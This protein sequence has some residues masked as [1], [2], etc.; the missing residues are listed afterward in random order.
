MA[1]RATSL[2][3]A[4]QNQFFR[5][6][7]NLPTNAWTDIYA[8]EHDYA[9]V[10]AG[11]NRD[12]LV[13]DFRQAVEKAIADGTTLEEFRRDFDRIVA[14][15]GWSYRGG[16]NW[17]SRVIYETNMRSSY[18]AGRLEQLMAVREE[19]P[20]W[21]YLHSDAVEHPRPKHESWN[22][23]V[24]RWDDPWWQYH[25]PINAWGCQCSVR[26]LSEDDLRRMGKD[27]PDEAPPIVWQA[28][29]IGQNSPDG[30]R[31]V[32]VPEGIDPGFEYMP[33]QARLDTAVPQPRNGGP[34]PPAGLPSTPASDPLPAPRPVPTN[35]L[36]DQDML[37]ADAI[38][39]FL[40][41]FGATLDKPAVFQ[42]VVGQRV[43]VGREMFAS[44]AGGDL[45]V[46]ES[47]M[48]KKWLM[49]AAEALRRP[50]EIWVRLDWV[51]SLKKAVV[52]R[53]YLA[54][55][56]VSGEAA[57]VQVVVE[58]DANGW[59]ASAA[60]VQPGQQPLAPYRQGVRLYQET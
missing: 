60:V 1:L 14:K 44:R 4:E 29:T 23:L 47:G 32:E 45:L 12:D 19:R 17:R 3:F 43:V 16:R 25:F 59:A 10:V 41:P 8:R 28:R 24:L 38:K 35:Q 18:M 20:Y 11:A 49:L 51:E 48:S 26:A 27:G 22:G 9:F 54:S 50:A 52:R 56:Q 21:Q 36:L 33:G 15:Y 58:L 40:R 42:D 34:T 53:R 5:R 30:P 57:P 37:D 7:L 2:P 6:K 31:V 46:A 39:R 55:L 13:Q